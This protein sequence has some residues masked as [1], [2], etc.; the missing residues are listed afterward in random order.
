MLKSFILGASAFTMIAA[1]VAASAAPV[2]H[3]SPAQSLS[4][5]SATRAGTPTSGKSRLAGGSIAAAVI[6][7]GVLAGVA[8]LII[9]KENDDD[10]D[11]PASR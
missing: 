3:R 1:P 9:D 7:V 5:S 8:Y 11:R 6:G 2:A 4:L 10:N